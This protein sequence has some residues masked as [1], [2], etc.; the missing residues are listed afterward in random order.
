MYIKFIDL[1][2][3]CFNIQRIT[4][5]NTAT[6]NENHIND[7]VFIFSLFQTPSNPTIA[8]VLKKFIGG[9]DSM[10]H[11]SVI[12]Y[13]K[14]FLLPFS[15]QTVPTEKNCRTEVGSDSVALW[16]TQLPHH[17]AGTSLE[18]TTSPEYREIGLAGFEPSI[19][20]SLLLKL[21]GGR[22]DLGTRGCGELA[23]GEREGG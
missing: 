6:Y 8:R 13:C 5:I 2:K 15:L 11:R 1:F 18:R 9:G 19:R 23:H 4:R 10:K 17:P 7:I 21:Q 20:G 3:L 12:R 22:F 14:T 16:K